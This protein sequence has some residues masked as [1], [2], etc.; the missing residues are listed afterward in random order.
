VGSHF[1]FTESFFIKSYFGFGGFNLRG[2]YREQ[3][4]YQSKPNRGSK[5]PNQNVGF[6]P[7]LYLGIN[8]GFK[9]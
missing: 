1:N 7:K 5:N 9:L 6:L 2:D 4:N 3:Y 8:I